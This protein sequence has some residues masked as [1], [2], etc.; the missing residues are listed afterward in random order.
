[1]VENRSTDRSLDQGVSS[2]ILG[3]ILY[4]LN[5]VLLR[6]NASVLVFLLTNKPTSMTAAIVTIKYIS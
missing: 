5:L 2:S 6:D 3:L 4:Q 1:M